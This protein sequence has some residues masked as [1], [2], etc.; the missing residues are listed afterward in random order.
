[1]GAAD[2][3]IHSAY[4]YDGTASV[5]QVLAAAKA[6]GLDTVAITDHDRI[7]GS[8][9]ATRLAPEYGLLAISGIEITTAEG[10]L[11]AYNVHQAI[12]PQLTLIETIR[13][14]AGQGGFCVAAHPMSQGMGMNS[15]T[16]YGVIEALRDE[17]VTGCLLGI[18]CYNATALDQP[19]NDAAIRL[20]QRT[21]LAR[22]GNSDSHVVQ[23]IGAGRTYYPG[24]GLTDLLLAL[25]MRQ[26]VPQHGQQMAFGK[27]LGLWAGAYIR[28]R[29]ADAGAS[30]L[31]F[32]A[33]LASGA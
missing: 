28:R 31:A 30:M 4:S 7:E 23:T 1:M 26:T 25:A 17:A 22:L 13:R 33:R 24:F 12:P 21:G 19:A 29:S 27:M 5:R 3:H 15:V 32:G 10:D 6:A 14:V 20:A 18:E 8:L 2:L 16:H 11:L 9:E